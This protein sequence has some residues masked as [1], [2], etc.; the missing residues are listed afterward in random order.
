MKKYLYLLGTILVLGGCSGQTSGAKNA[1]GD[2]PVKYVVCDGNEDN[3]IVSARFTD[4]FFC[5]N[6]KSVNEMLCDRQSVPNQVICRKDNGPHLGY[7]HC[8]P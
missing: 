5:E 3:C 2:T 6:Y 7:G 8:I 4:L 1:K